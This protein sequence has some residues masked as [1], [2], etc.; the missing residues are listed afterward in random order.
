MLVTGDGLAA[1]C[2][3]VM[4]IPASRLLRNNNNSSNGM[5]ILD[6]LPDEGTHINHPNHEKFAP[7][8]D[9]TIIYSEAVRRCDGGPIR[10][11]LLCCY[12]TIWS[13]GATPHRGLLPAALLGWTNY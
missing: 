12:A 9:K 8:F 5:E 10:S 11:H 4:R 13:Y 1:S 2:D 3:D 7:P 6:E